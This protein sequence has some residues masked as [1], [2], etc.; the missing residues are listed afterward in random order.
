MLLLPDPL[1]TCEKVVHSTCGRS[2]VHVEVLLGA[3]SF[4]LLLIDQAEAQVP[5]D[6]V[7]HAPTQRNKLIGAV[8][9]S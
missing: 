5:T 7:D 1:T 6:T 3:A 4:R 2:P 8:P 9:G